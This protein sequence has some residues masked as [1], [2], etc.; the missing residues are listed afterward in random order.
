MSTPAVVVGTGR[1]ASA[2]AHG[3]AGVGR[4]AGV[5]GRDAGRVAAL[6]ASCGVPTLTYAEA[7]TQV[8]DRGGLLVLAV[9]DDA[10]TVVAAELARVAPEVDAARG[11]AAVVHC[12][13]AT[14]PDALAALAARGWATG[15]WHPFQAFPTTAARLAPG[16]LCTITA[17]EP[18]ATRLETLA[19]DLGGVPAR[20][21]PEH[22]ATYHAAASLAVLGTVAAVTQAEALLRACGL[23]EGSRQ[24]LTDLARG[25]LAAVD[26]VGPA[27][28]LTGPLVRGD[29]GTLARHRAALDD[30]PPALDLYAAAARA[31]IPLLQVTGRSEAEIRATLRALDRPTGTGDPAASPSIRTLTPTPG[32]PPVQLKTMVSGK[33]HRARVTAADLHYVGSITIDE[34]LLDAAGIDSYERVQVVDIDNGARLETYTIPGER[35]SGEIQLNGAAARLVQPGD[36]VIVMAYQQVTVPVPEDWHPRVVLVDPRDNSIAE[37]I[38]SRQHPQALRGPQSVEGLAADTLSPDA[39]P[40]VASAE[41]EG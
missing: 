41:H 29:T 31:V 23:G 32:G 20:L 13:G 19:R 24:A 25:S 26:A 38:T 22:R 40:D 15:C 6:A 4:L 7:A 37:L 8:R 5:S 9:S 34:D 39:A 1:V 2:L 18:L 16:T 28:A 14:G 33:I 10:I 12:S 11:R 3:L 27:Q 35:G 30:Q 17:P 21:A 36:L